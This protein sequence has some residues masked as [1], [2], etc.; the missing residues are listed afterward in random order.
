[1]G[2]GRCWVWNPA[3]AERGE[4]G[5]FLSDRVSFFAHQPDALGQK[6]RNGLDNRNRDLGGIVEDEVADEDLSERS[7]ERCLSLSSM[8]WTKRL[9]G[10]AG[11]KARRRRRIVNS[12]RR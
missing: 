11:G 9:L 4:R 7:K 6:R 10:H 8:Q 5:A 12:M 3:N 2:Q 1:M